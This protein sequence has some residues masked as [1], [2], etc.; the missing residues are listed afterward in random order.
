MAGKRMRLKMLREIKLSRPGRFGKILLIVPDNRLYPLGEEYFPRLSQTLLIRGTYNRLFLKDPQYLTDHF[1]AVVGPVIEKAEID[2]LASQNVLSKI[3]NA[4]REQAA[5]QP[6]RNQILLSEIGR[7]EVKE[8]LRGRPYDMVVVIYNDAVGLG[9]LSCDLF[10][11]GFKNDKNLIAVFNGRS[12]LFALNRRVLAKL[13][14]HRFL[15]K[16][17]IPEVICLGMFFVLLP[18]MHIHYLVE[19]VFFRGKEVEADA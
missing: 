7:P 10:A 11:L 17:W 5:F 15:I 13:I 18:L 4:D 8:Y 6:I 1:F 14:L 2:L 12:R 3:A 9:N 16:A 19:K